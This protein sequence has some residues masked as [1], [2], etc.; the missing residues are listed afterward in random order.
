M[1]KLK[2][3]G[4]Q[5]LENTMGSIELI[6]TVVNKI[7]TTPIEQNHVIVYYSDEGMCIFEVIENT[8]KKLIVEFISTAS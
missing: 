7:H 1:Q 6:Q 8:P 4:F 2:I 3:K 5:H